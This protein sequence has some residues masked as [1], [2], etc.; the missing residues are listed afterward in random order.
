MTKY[1]HNLN[2]QNYLYIIY[3]FSEST[4]I[5]SCDVQVW[6]TISMMSPSCCLLK[7]DA[8]L[9][10]L[11]FSSFCV[12]IGMSQLAQYTS[13]AARLRPSSIHHHNDHFSIHCRIRIGLC[14]Q[15]FHL[16][17]SSVH[18]LYLRAINAVYSSSL[19]CVDIAILAIWSCFSILTMICQQNC[20]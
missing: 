10:I 18:P 1:I 8:R 13:Q 14:H 20:R 7:N 17:Q 11:Y 15:E 5:I 6:C 9:Y 19:S 12:L 3:I 4:F 2:E 16:S